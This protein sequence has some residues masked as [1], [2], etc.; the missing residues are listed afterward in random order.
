MRLFFASFFFVLL[1]PFFSLHSTQRGLRAR[2]LFAC[3]SS[4]DFSV[5]MD[6]NQERFGWVSWWE[7]KNSWNV[8]SLP[9]HG[10]ALVCGSAMHVIWELNWKDELWSSEVARVGEFTHNHLPGGFKREFANKNSRNDSL[11]FTYDSHLK[12]EK[13]IGLLSG[14]IFRKFIVAIFLAVLSARSAQIAVILRSYSDNF[15]STHQDYTCNQWR[16]V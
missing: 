15:C 1:Y 16:S 7:K 2:N 12:N 9:G 8:E 13:S 14:L 6:L 4:G 3:G 10:A 5:W 11:Q